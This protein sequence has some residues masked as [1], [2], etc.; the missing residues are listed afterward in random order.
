MVHFDWITADELYGS[1]GD[2]LDAL[3]AIG[4]RYVVEINK[5]AN[6]MQ[7]ENCKFTISK[8]AI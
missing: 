7:I 8:L 1:S 2:S 5:H 4:R 3:E 6:G